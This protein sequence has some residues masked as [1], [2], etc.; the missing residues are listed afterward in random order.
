MIYSSILAR[1][2]CLNL[3]YAIVDLKH[4]FTILI[5]KKVL[6]SCDV[7]TR[8]VINICIT[9]YM[10]VGLW[11]SVFHAPLP[12]TPHHWENTPLTIYDLTI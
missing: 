4:F 2:T 11:V 10:S 1:L 9:R 12:Q 7:V 6:L 8:R 3:P 5:W